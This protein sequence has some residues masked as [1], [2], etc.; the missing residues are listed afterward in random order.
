MSGYVA[1]EKRAIAE[2]YLIPAA[3]KLSGLNESNVNITKQY[4]GAFSVFVGW[5]GIHCSL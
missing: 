2:R 5:M 3:Q 4:K 1:E